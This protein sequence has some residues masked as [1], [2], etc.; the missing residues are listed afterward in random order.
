MYPR[1]ILNENLSYFFQKL[2][3]HPVIGKILVSSHLTDE[4]FNGF[5]YERTGQNE[6]CIMGFPL[7]E[8]DFFHTA[9]I[10]KT[11]FGS[12][13]ELVTFNTL[14]FDNSVE[15][16]GVDGPGRIGGFYIHKKE[17]YPIKIKRAKRVNIHGRQVDCSIHKCQL[18]G[19]KIMLSF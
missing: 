3:Q 10:L 18:Y 1:F 12:V 14:Y 13:I 16:F 6:F 2:E 17:R 7:S 9:F 11:R 8:F 15:Y 19:C 4:D 5:C